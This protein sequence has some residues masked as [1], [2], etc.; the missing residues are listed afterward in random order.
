MSNKMQGDKGKKIVNRKFNSFLKDHKVHFFSTEND[1]IKAS[2][3]E[4]FN[5]VWVH[6]SFLNTMPKNKYEYDDSFTYNIYRDMLA[7]QSKYIIYVVM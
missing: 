3:V 2:V 6:P 1:D 7:E 4:R 5:N